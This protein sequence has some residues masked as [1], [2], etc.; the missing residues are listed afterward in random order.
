MRLL[1]VLF[2]AI[3]FVAAGSGGAVAIQE[4]DT[5]TLTVTVVDKHGGTPGGVTITATWDGGSTTATTASNG[6]A[7]VDVPEGADV[8]LD[9][10]DD[11]YT[12]N[13]PKTVQDAAAEEVDLAVTRKGSVE[14]TVTDADGPVEDVNV[15]FRRDGTTIVTG[16]T[17]A[18]GIFDTGTIERREY[19]VILEKPGYYR[20]RTTV[21]VTGDVFRSVRMARGTVNV[22]VAVQDDHFS[23]PEPV[24]D[25][26]VTVEPI[27]TQRTTSGTVTFTV[28]VNDDYRVTVEK[29]GYART[30]RVIQ[31]HETPRDVTISVQREETLIVRPLN[32]KVVVGQSVLVEVVN[33]YGESVSGA[34]IRLDGE[35][36][37]ETDAAGE[38]RVPVESAGE[39]TIRARGEGIRSAPVVVTGVETGQGD[40]ATDSPTDT[41][42]AADGMTGTPTTVSPLPGFTTAT[43]LATLALV[44]AGLLAR[45][46]R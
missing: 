8:K 37:G 1:S 13:V 44:A 34:K 26:R 17:D 5:V 27:G 25:A 2:A 12:R 11:V 6:K 38:V 14:V 19:A 3:L 33:A 39:H 7:F 28:P 40:G 4:G 22:E 18:D 29:D 31:V 46:R 36:V 23:P 45:R 43:A 9:V 15:T 32:D 10:D 24:G 35:L 21:V 16:T 20:N 42:T 41:R 30:E